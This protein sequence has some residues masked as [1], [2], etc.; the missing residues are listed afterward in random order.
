MTTM[1]D[2]LKSYKKW[3]TIRKPL[4]TINRLY[5]TWFQKDKKNSALT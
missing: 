1:E 4:L 2:L 5:I 3:E